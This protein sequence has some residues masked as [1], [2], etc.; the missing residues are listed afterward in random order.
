MT[1][2]LV[3]NY[4]LIVTN[5]SISE[6]P[7]NLVP[8]IYNAAT[9]NC[10]SSAVNS[11]QFTANVH[12][13]SAGSGARATS[14]AQVLSVVLMGF[15]EVSHTSSPSIRPFA[16]QLGSFK[17]PTISPSPRPLIR[18]SLQTAHPSQEPSNSSFNYSIQPLL[19]S[20]MAT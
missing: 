1:C 11:G 10:I 17:Q 3:G 2:L 7:A 18:P 13:L 15:I 14:G 6:I 20:S 5:T 12:I 16:P 8:S 4:S 19:T 9:V